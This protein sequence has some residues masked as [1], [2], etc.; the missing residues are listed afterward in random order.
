M[1]IK[2]SNLSQIHVFKVKFQM[3]I[4]YDNFFEINFFLKRKNHL[5]SFNV[6][7]FLD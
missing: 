2:K 5:G 4:L 3:I 6:I 7:I 1:I